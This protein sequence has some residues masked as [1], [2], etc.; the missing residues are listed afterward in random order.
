MMDCRHIEHFD[1]DYKDYYIINS[2]S[3]SSSSCCGSSRI[4]NNN[5]NNSCSS[6]RDSRLCI[7]T[8][9]ICFPLQR[10]MM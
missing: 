1:Y 2:S 10:I 7:N 6:G 3:S 9:E 4:N 8:G 5:N